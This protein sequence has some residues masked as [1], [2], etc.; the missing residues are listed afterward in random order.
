MTEFKKYK[1]LEQER[2]ELKKACE[3]CKLFDIE[4]TN[5]D[6]LEQ[7]EK[8]EQ[9]NKRLNERLYCY[10]YEKDCHLQ[11]KQKDCAIKNYYKYKSALEEIREKIKSLNKD[12]YN[13][14]G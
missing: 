4:K 3:K 13:N 1:R 8:L 11:C 9:E 6:L 7:I 5:R 2:D 12:I 10:A 14:C